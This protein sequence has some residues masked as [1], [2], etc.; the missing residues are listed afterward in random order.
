MNMGCEIIFVEHRN[1]TV[2]AIE[3]IERIVELSAV[4]E[5]YKNIANQ[6]RNGLA[7]IERAGVPPYE[8]TH[9]FGPMVERTPQGQKFRFQLIKALK[10]NPPL[11]EFRVN[12][13]RETDPFD[14]GYAFRMIFFTYTKNG[15]QYVLF[16]NAVVKRAKTSREFEQLITNAKEVY[17]DFLKDPDF[18]IHRRRYINGKR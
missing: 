3:A 7:A 2:P 15:I 17:M 10:H 14:M 6:I 5:V 12:C 13:W 9:T 11:V 16:V 1:G 4:D 18:Y 8:L